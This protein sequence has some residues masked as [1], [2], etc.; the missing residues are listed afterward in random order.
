MFHATHLKDHS[1]A[2]TA[3]GPAPDGDTGLAA[4]VLDVL[5]PDV[6]VAAPVDE[7]VAH[8]LGA[9]AAVAVARVNVI[10]FVVADLTLNLKMK[11]GL[12]I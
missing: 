6:D 1:V 12:L 7:G 4:A 10:K 2:A 3:A 11:M 5:G 8:A 9:V